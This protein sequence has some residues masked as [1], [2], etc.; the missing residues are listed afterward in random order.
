ML[1][2]IGADSFE[3]LLDQVPSALRQQKPCDLPPA[4]SEFELRRTLS[5][6]AAENYD[7]LRSLSFLGAGF[8]DHIIPAAID[9]IVLR[10]EFYTAYTPYQ[11]EVAQ[12]TLTTIFEFQSLICALSGMEIANA[13]MYDGASAAAEAMLLAGSATRSERVLLAESIHPRTR[14][15]IET[16]LDGSALE[17]LTLP[18]RKGQV[19]LAALEQAL[20]EKPAAVLLQQPNFFG[21]LEPLDR[22]AELQ[23]RLSA[24]THLVVS[25]DPLS[26]ALLAP[27]AD[28]GAQTVIGDVQP[29]GI[30]PQFGG[31]SAGYFAT[32]ASHARRLPGRLVAEATDAEGRRGFVLT[33]QTRE[34]H[35]RREKAT[36]NICTNSALMALRATIFLSL[37]GP[38]GLQEMAALCAARGQQA[39]ERLCGIRG[40]ARRHAGPF[41]REFVLTLPREAEDAVERAYEAGGVLAGVPLSRFWPERRREL[42][43]AVTEKRTPEE[44]ETLAE[45]LEKVLA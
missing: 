9:Q 37:L 29:L 34:Q 41:W 4:Q 17:V 10:S 33:L 43:V 23:Q 26:L 25:A 22:V 13:S 38:T 5:G 11:A 14:G 19:D 30:P 7:P 27:P 45:T 15:V 44:I 12:G 18:E 40:V 3:T 6:L 24:E 1:A 28:F 2:A 36:S 16:Y 32:R 31:P 20:T 8:Y 39:A 21:L 35:I 42:L